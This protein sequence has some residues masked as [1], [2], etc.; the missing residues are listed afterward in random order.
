M[1]PSEEVRLVLAEIVTLMVS[2][3]VFD[4]LRA[5]ID[6]L[7]AIVRVLC[8]D[9]YYEVILEGCEAISQLA[10][11]GRDQ[12]LYF[13]ENMGRSVFTALVSKRGQV[14]QKGLDALKTVMLHCG[15]WKFNANI[16]EHLVGFRDPHVVPIKDFYEPT[17]KVNYLAI[18]L[19]DPNTSVRAHFYKTMGDMLLHLPDKKDLEPRL[20]PYLL[21]GLFDSHDP[22]KESTFDIIE[23]CG[24]LYE[25]EH[26][27]EIRDQK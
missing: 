21:T 22:I 11:N 15:T 25:E 10:E 2:E 14:R 27:Q 12:L 23:Q 6:A 4:C 1:E 3:T 13:S 16:L 18:F 7:V 19:T 24:A 9:P 26:E 17:T 20:F 5:Y 8:M